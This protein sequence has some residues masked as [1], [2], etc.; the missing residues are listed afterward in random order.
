MSSEECSEARWRI[1]RTLD[2]LAR[3]QRGP[4][5]PLDAL[6]AVRH[7]QHDLADARDLL[8]AAARRD[9]AT[10]TQIGTALGISR[11][12]VHQAHQRSQEHRERR[13]IEARVWKMTPVPRRRRFP[14]PFRRVA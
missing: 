1:G 7:A 10:W 9:G 5:R 14:W 8:T 11:Q 3:T 13:R 2:D 4:Q 12:A 6:R